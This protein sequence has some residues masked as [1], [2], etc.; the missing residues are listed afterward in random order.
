[1]FRVQGVQ[2]S[3]RIGFRAGLGF[4]VHQ[5]YER[6]SRCSQWGAQKFVGKGLPGCLRKFFH[7]FVLKP[8][9]YD[10]TMRNFFLE[11]HGK[12]ELLPTTFMTDRNDASVP[13]YGC[14]EVINIYS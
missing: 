9:G 4:Q 6:L 13:Q 2:G 10:S 5:N 14:T 11:V 12:Y 8:R 3:G 1:M 7:G